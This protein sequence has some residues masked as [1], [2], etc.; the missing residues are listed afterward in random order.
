MHVYNEELGLPPRLYYYACKQSDYSSLAWL[1]SKGYTL[2]YE[3][4][5]DIIYYNMYDGAVWLGKMGYFAK[6]NALEIAIKYNK[7]KIANWCLRDSRPIDTFLYAA[8]TGDMDILRKLIAE[9][10]T[11]GR[12]IACQIAAYFE[13][14]EM[15]EFLCTNGFPLTV[16]TSIN[17]AKSNS[18]KC[19]KIAHKYG[20]PLLEEVCLAAIASN[21]LVCLKFALQNKCPRTPENIMLRAVEHNNLRIVTWLCDH[22]VPCDIESVDQAAQLD[23]Y[24]ILKLLVSKGHPYK[25]KSIKWSIDNDE[26]LAKWFTD[27]GYTFDEEPEPEITIIKR[28]KPQT[29]T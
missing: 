17:A 24:D 16:E 10:K 8:G 7:R 15:L 14:A 29:T 21:S 3:D 20:A 1:N 13:Q 5:D 19:L 28:K 26:E 6:H 27:N 2:N 11:E 25:S 9:G 23:T 18:L 22:N 4:L 12:E